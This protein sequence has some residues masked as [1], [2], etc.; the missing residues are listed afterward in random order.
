MALQSRTAFFQTGVCRPKGVG[1][2]FPGCCCCSITLTH[3]FNILMNISQIM[4]G[5]AI[6]LTWNEWLGR[7][8]AGRASR[9]FVMWSNSENSLL[10]E[11]FVS[12]LAE[13]VYWISAFVQQGSEHFLTVCGNIFVWNSVFHS[14]H[15]QIWRRSTDPDL[16]LKM[17]WVWG[18][19]QLCLRSIGVRSQKSLKTTGLENFS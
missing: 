11:I 13:C 10:R 12:F 3:W 14:P 19:R 1:D 7:P 18:V 15:S 4:T 8:R 17:T 5:S 6:L 9:T 2:G 16:L